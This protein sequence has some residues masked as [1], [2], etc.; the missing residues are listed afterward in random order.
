M[1]L[2]KNSSLIKDTLCSIYELIPKKLLAKKIAEA[3]KLRKM[4]NEQNVLI[5]N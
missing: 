4:K 3:F 5:G 1:V 2:K